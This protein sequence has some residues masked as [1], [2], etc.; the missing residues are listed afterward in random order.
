MPRRA[1]G[2]KPMTPTERS[3]RRRNSQAEEIRL[4]RRAL[5]DALTVFDIGEDTQFR[6]AYADVIKRAQ[7]WV[8]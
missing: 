8:S 5:V 1:I 2:D 3:A 7:E 4:L 6:K